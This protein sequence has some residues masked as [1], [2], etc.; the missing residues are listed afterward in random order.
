MAHIS[1]IL[2][3]VSDFETCQFKEVLYVMSFVR[4]VCMYRQIYFGDLIQSS[5]EIKNRAVSMDYPT[6]SQRQRWL[7]KN[8]E[9][10]VCLTISLDMGW[11]SSI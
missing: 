11:F 4:L 3:A 6:S 10:L 8:Q 1:V 9:E 5:Y 7:F 2:G